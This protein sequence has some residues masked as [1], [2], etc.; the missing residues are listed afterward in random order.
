MKNVTLYVPKIDFSHIRTDRRLV[1]IP[2]GLFA[3]RRTREREPERKGLRHDDRTNRAFPFPALSILDN[4]HLPSGLLYHCL[5]KLSRFSSARSHLFS[6]SFTLLSR[7][8]R[9]GPARRAQRDSIFTELPCVDH[10]TSFA[11]ALHLPLPSPLP[12]R[13]NSPRLLLFAMRS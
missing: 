12:S 6:R 4:G 2:F 8:T 1:T 5:L 13:R 10:S 9:P 3:R 7:V 11:H